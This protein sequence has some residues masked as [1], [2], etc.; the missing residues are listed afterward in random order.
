MLNLLESWSAVSILGTTQ[1][2]ERNRRESVWQPQRSLVSN[3]D[4]T[5]HRAVSKVVNLGTAL[6][7]HNI[8]RSSH[9]VNGWKTRLRCR[10]NRRKRWL[11]DRLRNEGLNFLSARQ[12]ENDCSIS[13]RQTF[14]DSTQQ[15]PLIL[16]WGIEHGVFHLARC[17]RCFS[18]E[19]NIVVLLCTRTCSDPS[20]D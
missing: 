5:G 20:L 10:S 6:K 1:V 17:R 13:T 8:M 3:K 16:H 11:A 7:K 2:S 19:K 18:S 12:A 14:G 9:T 4:V 15:L